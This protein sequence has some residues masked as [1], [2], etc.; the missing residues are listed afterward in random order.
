[1]YGYIFPT[2]RRPQENQ[3]V[4]FMSAFL[5]LIVDLWRTFRASFSNEISLENL[6]VSLK[7][8]LF[9]RVGNIYT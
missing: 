8:S 2:N 7:F 9:D 6:S 1:M 3:Y 5:F 4:S